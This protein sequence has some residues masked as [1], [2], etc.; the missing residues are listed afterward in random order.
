VW[1]IAAA[2]LCSWL[3]AVVVQDVVQPSGNPVCLLAVLSRVSAVGV[4]ADLG[5]HDCGRCV[6][7]CDCGAKQV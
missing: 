2:W 3:T 1:D 4:G 6:W 7:S 5:G